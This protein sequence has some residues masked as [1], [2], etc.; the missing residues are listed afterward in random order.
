MYK[1]LCGEIFH[2]RTIVICSQRRH[3][4]EEELILRSTTSVGE[5]TLTL[6]DISIV[7]LCV[8]LSYIN[9][10]KMDLPHLIVSAF[11]LPQG[12]GN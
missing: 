12:D 3:Q 8:I 11:H 6:P 2:E 4:G 1:A 7:S 5:G 9:I 10:N